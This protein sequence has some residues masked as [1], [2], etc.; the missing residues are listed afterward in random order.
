VGDERG[1]DVVRVLVLAAHPDDETLG[2]G[3][4]MAH[5]INRG[6]EVQVCILTDGVTARHGHTRLQEERAIEACGVLGVDD[7]VFYGLPDQR[8][9]AMPLIDLIQPIEESVKAFKPDIVYT[10]FNQDANQDHRTTFHASMVATRPTGGNG[11]KRVLCYEA[12]SSTEWAAPL[13]GNVFA[14]NVFVDITTSLAKK[15][16]AMKM[17]ASTH[18]SEVRPYPH[19][20]SFEAIETYAKRHGIVVGYKAAE[21]FMLVRELISANSQGGNSDANSFY[22]S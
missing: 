21:P 5:H 1:D 16:E 20:R 14:A 2:V 12:A 3:G 13:A 18:E 6:D 11:V 22:H 7:V 8:L 19:P 9:D 15:L 10:H 4:T 17:Y